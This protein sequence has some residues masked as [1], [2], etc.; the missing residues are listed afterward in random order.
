MFLS[1]CPLCWFEEVFFKCSQSIKCEIRK[2]KTLLIKREMSQVNVIGHKV[3]D[4]DN[5]C[6]ITIKLFTYKCLQTVK[7]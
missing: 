5:L 7:A 4:Q 3:Q 6:F 1:S 2:I